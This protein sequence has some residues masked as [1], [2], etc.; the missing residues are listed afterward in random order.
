MRR[1]ACRLVLALLATAP[2]QAQIVPER[3]ALF[4][5]FNKGLSDQAEGG[6]ELHL[7]GAKLDRNGHLEFTTASQYAELGNEAMA[8]IARRLRGIKAMSIGGWFYS[9]RA[10][11]QTFFSRGLLETGSLGERLFRPREDWVNFC[12]GSD[13]HGFLLGTIHGN[14]RMPFP[15]VTVNELEIQS[16]NQLVVVKDHHGHQS[17]YQN[18]RRSL[19]TTSRPGPA[20]RGHSAR[21]RRASRSGSRCRWVDRSARPGSFRTG[22]QPMR[23]GETTWPRKTAIVL[24]SPASR[25]S[26][27]R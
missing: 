24:P 26:C 17:F 10:G 22:C 14:G 25:S 6:R 15:Y 2:A 1:I 12:L 23:S 19:R 9:R 16:W 20:W 8:L 5:D 11:E 3:A 7:E 18:G 13:Q 4:F 21:P 27:E